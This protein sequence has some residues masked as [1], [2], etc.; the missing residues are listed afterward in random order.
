MRKVWID[1]FFHWYKHRFKEKW[2]HFDVHNVAEITKDKHLLHGLNE[3]CIND[4]NCLKIKLFWN[5]YL[6]LQTVMEWQNIAVIPY[7]TTSLH[8]ISIILSIF[9]PLQFWH[10]K[11]KVMWV[12]VVIVQ[13][14]S[15]SISC[16]NICVI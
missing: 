1:P 4:N 2:L 8:K 6:T 7:K 11:C 12:Y 3:N 10:L 9:V 16:D 14:S 15:F 13:S 5:N